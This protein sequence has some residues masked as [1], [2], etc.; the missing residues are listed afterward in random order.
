MS[1]WKKRLVSALGGDRT[2]W[3]IRQHV[4]VGKGILGDFVHRF[5][6]TVLLQ[7]VRYCEDTVNYFQ[8]LHASE[9]KLLVV[10]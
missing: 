10:F 5:L 2:N 8:I 7:V 6:W 3:K 4:L 9:E 1:V